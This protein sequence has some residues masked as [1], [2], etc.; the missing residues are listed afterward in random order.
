MTR[1]ILED[2]SYL[3][4]FKTYMIKAGAENLLYAYN[5]IIEIQE[6]MEHL[7]KQ[8]QTPRDLRDTGSGTYAPQ[9]G[10]NGVSDHDDSIAAQARYV[11]ALQLS[12]VAAISGSQVPKSPRVSGTSN[13]SLQTFFYYINTLY[14]TYLTLGATFR[15]DISKEAMESFHNKL[16]KCNVVDLD[17]LKPIESAT[18][19]KLVKEHLD[20]FLNTAEYR[21]LVRA[22]RGSILI[23]AQ[24]LKQPIS[25]RNIENTIT[26]RITKENTNSYFGGTA[27]EEFNSVPEIT[28]NNNQ[29]KPK[30]AVTLSAD[31]PHF[32]QVTPTDDVITRMELK[33]FVHSPH[34][35]IFV[36]YLEESGMLSV[37]HFY[38]SACSYQMAKFRN[39]LERIAACQSIFDRYISRNSDDLIGLPDVVRTEIVTG[40]LEASPTLFKRA[41]EMAFEF[42]HS[43]H[44][45]IFKNKVYEKALLTIDPSKILETTCTASTMST[46]ATIDDNKAE[47][48]SNN[49]CKENKINDEASNEESIAVAMQIQHKIVIERQHPAS[50]RACRASRR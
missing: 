26:Q 6:R 44:W 43:P 18:F 14:D 27:D 10:T 40:L 11:P 38:Q 17:V 1:K 30:M 33:N 9:G 21:G 8:P 2:P 20:K 15:L 13:A 34:N 35:E 42:M 47:N 3:A 22:G 36:R 24:G 4:A 41:A 28:S 45:K 16:G 5:E 39:N 19:E 50:T 12:N 7:L 49:N 32:G 29:T 23:L 37:M 46:T 31:A 48:T 25:G